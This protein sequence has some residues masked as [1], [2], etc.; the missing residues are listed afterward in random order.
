[1]KF[2]KYYYLLIHCQNYNS[3]YNLMYDYGMCYLRLIL[4]SIQSQHFN[5]YFNVFEKLKVLKC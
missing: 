3:E 5:C 2:I 1:M 4:N